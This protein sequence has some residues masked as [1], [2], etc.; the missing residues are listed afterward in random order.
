[1]RN[2]SVFLTSPTIDEVQH[3]DL[4]ILMDMLVNETETY[5]NLFAKE[6]FSDRLKLL[7][8]NIEKL[9][10]AI[11]KKKK[12]EKDPPGS[13]QNKGSGNRTNNPRKAGN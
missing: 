8:E 3:L 1:M 12:S 11:T 6:G 9:Q 2:Y 7:R 4:P 13:E 10:E 5:A